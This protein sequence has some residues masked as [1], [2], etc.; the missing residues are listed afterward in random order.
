VDDLL[1][2]SGTAE[3]HATHLAAVLRMH[4]DKTL[5]GADY[6]EFLGH[7]ISE[8]GLTPD[9]ARVAAMMALTSPTSVTVCRSL[10]GVF[11]FFSLYVE[12]FS[13]IRAAHH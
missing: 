9:Q 7:L 8:K 10:Y 1:N 5:I 4:P 13:S 11:N 6:V 3:E 2:F 12:A